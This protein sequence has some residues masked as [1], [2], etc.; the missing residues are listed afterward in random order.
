MRRPNISRPGPRQRG[1]SESG[2]RH[3]PQPEGY[4]VYRFPG[5]HQKILRQIDQADTLCAPRTKV[6][7]MNVSSSYK[8][9]RNTLDEQGVHILEMGK[10]SGTVQG[11][12]ATN[13]L[14]NFQNILGMLFSLLHFVLPI[15]SPPS[16]P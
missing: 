12:L 2:V 13:L 3:A 1:R 15:P 6:S 14:H 9:L 7:A 11:R 8:G 4:R 16:G 5:S 10:K